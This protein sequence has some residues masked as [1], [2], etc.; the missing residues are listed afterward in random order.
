M[1]PLK[2]D[3]LLQLWENNWN[4][5]V[6]EKSLHLIALA[7]KTNDLKQIAQ[8]SLGE[9]DARLLLLRKWMFGNNLLNI[10]TCPSCGEQVEW[11]MKV[12]DLIVHKPKTIAAPETFEFQLDDFLI[13][14]RLI[15]SLDMLQYQKAANTDSSFLL[16]NCILE[17]RKGN[18]AFSKEH[19]PQPVLEHLEEKL[20]KADPQALINL[21]MDCPACQH[22]WTTSFSILHFIWLEIENWVKHILQEVYLL[23]KNFNWSEKDILNM[24]PRRRQLYL[25]MLK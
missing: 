15:H 21:S 10:A 7:S 1:R 4:K 2:A 8:L 9:R 19:L 12:D 18:E 6:L 22:Q 23:A 5:S 17:V 11:E 14:Y 20:S 3:E 16:R 13:R 24:S 25:Q